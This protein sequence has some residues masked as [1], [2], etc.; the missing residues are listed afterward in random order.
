[1]LPLDQEFLVEVG[2]GIMPDNE[3]DLFLVHV[4][5]TL[6]L[7]VGTQLARALSDELLSTFQALVEARDQVKAL[8]WLERHCPSYA[9]VVTNELQKLKQEIIASRDRILASD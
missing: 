8:A 4:H 1:M 7:R 9:Q 5:E 6:E 2:L 3:K